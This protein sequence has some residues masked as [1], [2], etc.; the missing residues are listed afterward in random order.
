[1]TI[2]TTPREIRSPQNG[3]VPTLDSPAVPAR[4]GARVPI[5]Q[6]IGKILAAAKTGFARWWAWTSRPLSLRAAWALSAVDPARIPNKSGI[7]R[8]LWR[9]S[10]ATDRI[11]L[12]ALTMLAPTCVTGPLR[13]LALRPTRRYGLYLTL[14]ALT[15]TYIIT[16][17]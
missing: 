16:K 1:M 7:L 8:A 10:N 4:A 6:R 11:I 15:T 14:L 12:F 5:T 2:L 3:R 17:E 9:I 13:W